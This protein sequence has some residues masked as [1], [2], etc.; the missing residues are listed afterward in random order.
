MYKVTAPRE[1]ASMRTW[2]LVINLLA[3]ST[4]ASAAAVDCT[5]SAPAGA[6][7]A[8]VT[9]LSMGCFGGGLLFDMFSVNSAPPGTSIFVSAIGTGSVV[10]PQ[11][12]SLGFQIT[13]P[14]P[15]VDTILQYR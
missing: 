10:G 12:F 3:L 11:G 2:I 7:G 8:N 14:T 1:G 6:V 5:L 4:I 15:P 9:S 13:T